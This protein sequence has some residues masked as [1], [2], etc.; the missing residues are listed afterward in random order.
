MTY[1]SH[2]IFK[3]LIDYC[4]SQFKSQDLSLKIYYQVTLPTW[5]S[6][7]F[8]QWWPSWY[9][10]SWYRVQ[11]FDYYYFFISSWRRW[12]FIIFWND[13]KYRKW[14]LLLL[15]VSFGRRLHVNVDGTHR[16]FGTAIRG[17]TST[18]RTNGVQQVSYF[19]LLID[20]E[21]HCC[22]HFES[23]VNSSNRS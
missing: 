3:S 11:S 2:S 6:E 5:A 15:F 1:T 4:H 18:I 20:I 23:V 13:L 19:F 12:S 21:G 7:L 16:S 17:Q 10:P 8:F 14:Q 9:V 22:T